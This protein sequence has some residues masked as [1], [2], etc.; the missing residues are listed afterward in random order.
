MEYT[1]KDNPEI[2]PEVRTGN[3]NEFHEYAESKERICQ[4]ARCMDCG[5][6]FCQSAMK[7]KGMVTGCP[8]HNLIPEWNDAVAM[9]NLFGLVVGLEKAQCHYRFDDKKD[10]AAFLTDLNISANA[11]YAIMDAIVGMDGPDV[12][13]AEKVAIKL[14]KL[15]QG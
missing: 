2:S 3:F 13:V 4:A 10:F 11:S 1:R 5:V 7:L 12:S 9:K 15:R 14:R 8:L 6:P